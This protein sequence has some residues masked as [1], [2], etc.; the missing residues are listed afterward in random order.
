MSEA[1]KRDLWIYPN[2]DPDEAP[3]L[4]A[5]KGHCTQCGECCKLHWL[6]SYRI[7]GCK[8]APPSPEG[9][10]RSGWGTTPI[11]AED[12]EGYWRYWQKADVESEHVP[13]GS[14][15]DSGICVFHDDPEREEICRKWPVMPSDLDHF[16]DCTFSFER[17]DDYDQPGGEKPP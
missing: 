9:V 17:V 13:C 4:W 1:E 2:G 14:Y 8:N 11:V 12:W 15:D 6:L 16:P 7:G 3:E 5:R 10:P